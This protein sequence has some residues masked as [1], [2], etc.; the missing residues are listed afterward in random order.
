MKTPLS[1]AAAAMTLVVLLGGCISEKDQPEQNPFVGIWQEVNSDIIYTFYE[2]LDLPSEDTTNNF[3]YSLY[4]C[5]LD[6]HSLEKVL[7]YIRFRIER[8]KKDERWIEYKKNDHTVIC[9]IENE[10]FLIPIT[11]IIGITATPDQYTKLL[12]KDMHNVTFTLN[13]ED[14]FIIGKKIITSSSLSKS[15]KEYYKIKKYV[16]EIIYHAAIH[17]T[18]AF[19]AYRCSKSG[20]V[21]RIRYFY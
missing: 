7:S 17:K 4:N 16:A 20:W 11:Q 1:A 5:D 9:E 6:W 19:S 12:F 2:S 13:R 14:K 10:N 21:L 3:L 18:A 8:I 15:D